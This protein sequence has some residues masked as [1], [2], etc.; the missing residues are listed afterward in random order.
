[1]LS[2][3][4]FLALR[5]SDVHPGLLLSV[6]NTCVQSWRQAR[7]LRTNEIFALRCTRPFG[8]WSRQARS[9]AGTHRDTVKRLMCSSTVKHRFTDTWLNTYTSLLRTVFLV[10]GERRPPVCLNSTRLIR[11][12]T[13]CGPPSVRINEVDCICLVGFHLLS[14]KLKTFARINQTVADPGRE[15]PPQSNTVPSCT[16][17]L[18]V[19]SRCSSSRSH[20]RQGRLHDEPKVRLRGRLAA[21]ARRDIYRVTV[22]YQ[23]R[24]YFVLFWFFFFAVLFSWRMINTRWQNPHREFD[25]SKFHLHLTN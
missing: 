8:L 22:G 18:K 24:S 25:S 1:M 2:F 6:N 12:D 13:F 3:A 20:V 14:M 19:S 23:S 21:V 10:P 15:D 7:P 5:F 17:V 9:Q 16:D 11:T 4:Y